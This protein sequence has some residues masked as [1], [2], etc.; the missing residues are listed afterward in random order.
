MRYAEP[1]VLLLVL[2]ACA[3]ASWRMPGPLGGLGRG[4]DESVASYLARQ[5]TEAPKPARTGRTAPNTT[6]RKIAAAAESFVGDGRLLVGGETYRFDCSGLVEA[7]LATAGVDASGSSAMLYEKA[8]DAGLLHRR[9]QPS[10]GDVAFFDNTYD[11]DG[12]GR[13][14]D[15]LTHTA[16]VVGVDDAGTVEMVHVGS[17][18]VVR[19]VMNLKAPHEEAGADG[20]LNDFLRARSKRDPLGTKH[21][22]GE[23]W[24]GFGSFWAQPGA[25]ATR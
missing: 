18:G 3:P 19:F 25:V 23:L 13:L 7:A 9:R 11:R 4:A 15:E 8:R 5:T 24:V 17:T 2:A 1:V 21:L 16:I 12:N 10:P 20:K 6:A 14:D 22:A